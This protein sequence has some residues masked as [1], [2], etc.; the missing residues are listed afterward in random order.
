MRDGSRFTGFG[1]GSGL[2]SV[3]WFTG[4]AGIADLLSLVMFD[5]GHRF[6]MEDIDLIRTDFKRLGRTGLRTLA[7]AIALIGIDDDIPFTR[8]VFETIVCYHICSMHDQSLFRL[9]ITNAQ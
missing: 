2:L 1:T 8:A 5:K 6:F 3:P 9:Q 4:S 7:V